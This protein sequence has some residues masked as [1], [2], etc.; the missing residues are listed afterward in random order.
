MFN[1]LSLLGSSW[2]GGSPQS[3]L[4]LDYR[5]PSALQILASRMMLSD[6]GAA[7]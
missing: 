3:S 7:R 5:E 2:G 4:T 1:L 6:I